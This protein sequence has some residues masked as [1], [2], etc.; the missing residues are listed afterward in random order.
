MKKYG[1]KVGME[2]VQE[3]PH[4]QLS[5][6]HTHTHCMQVSL[7]AS[8]MLYPQHS[9]PMGSKHHMQGYLC[10]ESGYVGELMWL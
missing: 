10:V 1:D 8:G 7:T 4:I 9:W 6:S 3:Q 5:T 2:C